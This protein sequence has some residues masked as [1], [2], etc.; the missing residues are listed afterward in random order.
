MITKLEEKYLKDN[1]LSEDKTKTYSKKHYL[2][3]G[4]ILGICVSIACLYFYSCVKEVLVN[5]VLDEIEF[6]EDNK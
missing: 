5:A 2:F 6:T 3:L 4:I 1:N